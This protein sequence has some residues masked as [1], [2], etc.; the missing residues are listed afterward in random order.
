M[1]EEMIVRLLKIYNLSLS[2]RERERER[3]IVQLVELKMTTNIRIGRRNDETSLVL[4][5]HQLRR[6]SRLNKLSKQLMRTRRKIR[7]TKE[8]SQHVP[9]VRFIID[10]DDLMF[11]SHSLILSL[12]RISIIKK[13]RIFLYLILTLDK[14][15]VICSR[16]LSNLFSIRL[17][18]LINSSND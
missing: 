13:S 18:H 9:V 8:C 2:R 6:N 5:K 17:L 3:Q 4:I 12:N 10:F 11:I 14:L 7:K 1:K 15:C 16:N